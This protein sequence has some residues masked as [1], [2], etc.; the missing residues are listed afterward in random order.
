MSDYKYPGLYRGLVYDNNDPEKRGRIRVKIPVL[1]G[2][3]VSGWAMPCVPFGWPYV[4]SN[5]TLGT[6][7][8]QVHV[9]P[10]EYP[11]VDTVWR[12]KV[13]ADDT[14]HHQARYVVPPNNK[15]VWIMFENGNIDYPVWMGT[16]E[17][18][19]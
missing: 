7:H 8:T 12:G 9:M 14:Y 4:E 2:N 6:I 15:P 10:G 19:L 3:E 17:Y 1:L 16:W 11:A 5:H 13:V 18:A